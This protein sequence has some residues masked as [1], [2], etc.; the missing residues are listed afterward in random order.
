MGQMMG[1]SHTA[2]NNMMI[3]M[4]GEEGEEQ[5]H[6]VMGKRLSECDINAEIPQRFL[7]NG[8][9]F[10][11]GMMGNWTPYTYNTSTN[12]PTMMNFG[13][14]IFGFTFM[15]FFWVILIIWTVALIKWILSQNKIEKD[16]KKSVLD[17]LKERYAKGEMEK[18]EFDEKRK[19]LE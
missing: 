6:V 9:M 1:E 4:I 14:W 10:N 12:F 3:T 11:G 18:K 5:I 15:I 13:F 8:M 17:I 16:T 2:M 19:D 7:N